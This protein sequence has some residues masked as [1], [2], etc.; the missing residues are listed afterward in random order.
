MD[1][2][3]WTMNID[4]YV[5]VKCPNTLTTCMSILLKMFIS[6]YEISARIVACRI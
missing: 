6:S 4:T 2:K 3:L 5:L 1:S